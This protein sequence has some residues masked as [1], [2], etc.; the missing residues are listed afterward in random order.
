MN[1][2]QRLQAQTAVHSPDVPNQQN[3]PRQ[4]EPS[5]AIPSPDG[6]HIKPNHPLA[7]SGHSSLTP[8]RI[9]QYR[10]L[11]FHA[12]KT[13]DPKRLPD[14]RALIATLPP[15]MGRPKN[16]MGACRWCRRPCL[17]TKAW[18]PECLPAYA[19]AVGRQMLNAFE[20]L[21]PWADC[22]CGKPGQEL[23][24]RVALAVAAQ[25]GERQRIRA[26]T[27]TNLQWLCHT[28]HLAKTAKDMAALR[29]L[30][31]KHPGNPLQLDLP[32]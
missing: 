29:Y 28:C 20:P 12:H 4:P 32:I 21:I 9:R 6:S 30:R 23:D 2:Q 18:H 31:R 13:I 17:P 25:L 8:E 7:K 27:L 10:G 1:D 11:L 22:P 16:M 14:S 15:I 24:H 19:V 26:Y 5:P 3:A